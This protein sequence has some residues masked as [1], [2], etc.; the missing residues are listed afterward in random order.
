MADL[1]L[2]LGLLFIGFLLGSRLIYKKDKFS[3]V[4]K[5]QTVCI[6]FLVFTMGTRMGSNR[7]IID[8]L[9]TIG[10]SAL[11]F[12]VVIFILVVLFLHITRKALRMNSTGDLV[13]KGET[14]KEK[15]KVKFE[16]NKMT[17]LVVLAVLL[18]MLFGFYVILNL[19]ESGKIFGGDILRFSDLASNLI[20]IELCFLLFFVGIDLGF[21]KG[22]FSNIKKVGLRILVFPLVTIIASLIGG[23]I[24]SLVLGLTIKEGLMI[25]AGFGWYSLAPG[26]IMDAG[27]I[28]ASAIAFL[29]NVLREMTAI[30]FIPF[31]ANGIGFI[32]TIG[33]PGAAAMDVCL[34]VIEKATKPEV[35]IY[36]FISGVIL[37]F[38]VPI[39]VP[40]I[41]SL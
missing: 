12:T 40:L 20:R 16:L 10:L 4:G 24:S 8:N 32:E 41:I 30:L 38:L 39:V 19:V 7:E 23:V 18:G 5:I 37:S 21:S 9:K 28:T 1:L 14:K 25:A 17:V 35:A 36:G 27:Y 3:F 29:H 15:T 34:P 11:L 26:L 22:A 2:Y 6:F 31:V 13:E 33:L